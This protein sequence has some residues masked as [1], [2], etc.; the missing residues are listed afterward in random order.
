MQK[1]GPS[2]SKFNAALLQNNEYV[3]MLRGKFTYWNTKYN[4]NHDK[5]TKWDLVK[6]LIHIETK[7][8]KKITKQN[9]DLENELYE[10]LQHV[11][12]NLDE[13]Q[14]E[15]LLSEYKVIIN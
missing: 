13:H 4:N 1:K 8:I 7:K 14:I 3:E 2:L 6:S 12:V 9:K 5:N 11:M 15:S 10:Q